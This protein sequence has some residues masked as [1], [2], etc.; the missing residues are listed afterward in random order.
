MRRKSVGFWCGLLSEMMAFIDKANRGKGRLG[1]NMR[2]VLDVYLRCHWDKQNIS[3]WIYD[4][5]IEETSE[6]KK[7]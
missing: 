5:G 7:Y 6:L 4:S 1:G 2:F 3:S